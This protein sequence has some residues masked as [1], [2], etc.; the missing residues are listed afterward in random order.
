MLRKISHSLASTDNGQQVFQ[1]YKELT[2]H[3]GWKVHQG[4]IIEIANNL[5][6]ELLS[7]GFTKLS[8]EEKDAQQRAMFI[9]K[10]IIDF[11][12]DPLKGAK[13]YATYQQHNINMQKRMSGS[14]NTKRDQ[15]LYP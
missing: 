4:F 15:S 8:K 13:Q 14:K 7:E 10:E 2:Q 6:A 12:N 11:L 1:Q 3:P 9:A 5:A